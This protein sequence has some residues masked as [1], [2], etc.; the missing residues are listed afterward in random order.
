VHPTIFLI[1]PLIPFEALVM[2]SLLR[3]PTP[4]VHQEVHV[5]GGGIVRDLVFG[6]NDGLIAAF[7]IVSGVHGA[8][9]TSKIIVIAGTAEVVGGMISMGMGAYLS[10]KAAIEYIRSERVREEY[11]VEH[12][13]DRE[14][15]EIHDI[16]K[17]KGFESPMLEAIVDHICADKK[18]WVNIMM[19]E[20]LNLSDEEAL[21][22]GRSAFATGG[23]FALAAAVPV[24]PY[25]LSENVEL[26]FLWSLTL[27]ISVLF[28]VGASKTV[29]TGLKWWRSG[30]EAMII[31]GLAASATYI[32]GSWVA[33][34]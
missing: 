9:L 2:F 6:A 13:P 3:R 4:G 34:L 20:E 8:Q 5:P 32:I 23:A 28:F 14:R 26:N 24:L 16:Y 29:V 12:F 17:E 33:S 1:N 31:G 19:R 15:K 22:P 21:S 27:T 10:V 25:V 18:R 30:L 7:A 11:E